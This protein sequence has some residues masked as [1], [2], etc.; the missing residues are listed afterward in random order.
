[1]GSQL[2]CR[3]LERQLR[4]GQGRRQRAEME[5]ARLR[6]LVRWE[7]PKDGTHLQRLFL[8]NFLFWDDFRFPETFHIPFTQLTLMSKS[9]ITLELFPK[10]RLSISSMPLPEL[11]TSFASSTHTP[12]CP[13]TR[14][15]SPSSPVTAPQSS[16]ESPSIWACVISSHG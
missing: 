7:H 10:L 8:F 3:N 16:L 4:A 1:M 2:L 12:F 14:P 5:R 13:S 15:V 9:Y 11:Q 6:G